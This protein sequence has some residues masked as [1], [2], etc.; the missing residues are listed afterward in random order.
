MGEEGEGPCQ[1]RLAEL[2]L[3]GLCWGAY[4]PGSLQGQV[5]GPAGQ[6]PFTSPAQAGGGSDSQETEYCGSEGQ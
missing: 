5:P 4:R 3:L 1:R 6:G 2:P